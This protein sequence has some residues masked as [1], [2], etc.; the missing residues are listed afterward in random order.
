MGKTPPRPQTSH[1]S[2]RLTLPEIRIA[3]VPEHAIGQAGEEHKEKS[4]TAS[5]LDSYAFVKTLRTTL[6]GELRKAIVKRTGQEVAVKV[7]RMDLISAGTS[8][9]GRRVL[10]DVYNESEVMQALNKPGHINVLKSVE[11]FETADNYFLVLEYASRGELFDVVA[12]AGRL[13][14]EVAKPLFLQL[15]RG[16]KYIHD[17]GFCHLDLSLEN[18]L[19]DGL[20]NLKVAD[21]GLARSLSLDLFEINSDVPQKPGKVQYMAPEIYSSQSFSGTLADSWSLGIILFVMLAGFPP[22]DV[23]SISDLRFSM[24]YSGKLARLLQRWRLDKVI[25]SAAVSLLSQLLAPPEGRLSVDHLL[26]HEWLLEFNS[27]EC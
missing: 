8:T 19:M 2:Y 21:F 22:F 14:E 15:V 10:E 12:Q 26:N 3:S 5:P 1:E 16:V 17:Q 7:C 13:D 11:S 18:V 24:I 20:G 23:P 25:S 27:G 6:Q 9:S 4:G